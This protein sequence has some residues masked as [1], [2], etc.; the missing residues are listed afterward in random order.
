MPALFSILVLGLLLLF[1]RELPEGIKSY[2]VASIAIYCLGA[3]LL[4]MLHRLVALNYEKQNNNN[5]SSIPLT[6]KF[7][8]YM[9]HISWF[10]A[11][12]IYNFWRCV[13]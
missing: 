4:G 5:E 7:L 1:L 11:L 3:A 13:L 6:G 2:L 10:A 9:L 12:I 8:L